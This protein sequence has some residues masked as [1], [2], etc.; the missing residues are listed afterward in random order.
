MQGVVSVLLVCIHGIGSYRP[1]ETLAAAADPPVVESVDRACDRLAG[2]EQVVAIHC[3]GDCI[4]QF[5]RLGEDVAVEGTCLVSSDA[6][7]HCVG[8]GVQREEVPGVPDGNQHLT[9][10]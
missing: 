9:A 10:R 4:S 7:T 5:S 3:L 8:V 1:P 2:S 6:A